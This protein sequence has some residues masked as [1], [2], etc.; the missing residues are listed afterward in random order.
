[1]QCSFYKLLGA[2]VKEKLSM[3]RSKLIIAVFALMFAA[4]SWAQEA[5]S[6]KIH[7]PYQSIRALG[8]GN[9]FSAVV[10][11]NTAIFYNPAALARLT[12]GHVSITG[13]QAQLDPDILDFVDEVSSAGDQPGNEVQN[14]ID[15][16]ESKYGEHF[17]MRLNAF[18]W[19]WARPGWGV[20]LVP[21]DFSLD[22]ELD[23]AVG[24]AL[25]VVAY[26]DLQVAF[27]YAKSKKIFGDHLLSF[28][29]TAK[30]VYRANI[31]KQLT[32]V[33]LA[34]DSDIVKESDFREGFTVDVDLGV[35]YTPKFGGESGFMKW[36]SNRE[37]TFSFVV[38]NALDYGFGTNFNLLNDDSGEPSKLER[39]FDVGGAFKLP[40][41]WVW[42][43]TLALDFRDIGHSNYTFEKG[44]H[45]GA[46][47]KWKVAS[48][49]QGAWRVGLQQAFDLAYWTAG[50]T[51]QFAIFRLDLATFAEEVGTSNEPK[52]SRRYM[53]KMS[54]DW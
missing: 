20:A 25:N 31:D 30:A 49:F 13:I 17:G 28:G 24:P 35:L 39:R 42:S 34:L 50:F 29:A 5:L 22:I 32:A 10:N 18:E 51:G 48:W 8:M 9:A 15:V 11:D 54:V 38:R 6:F 2:Q 46:E 41:W 33:E 45:L 16:I 36:V 43:S 23:Q 12:E 27:G 37:P 26:Q 47:F 19:L 40:D 14:I 7:Q 52:D 3:Y 21:L 4:D 1:M 53:L 44:F